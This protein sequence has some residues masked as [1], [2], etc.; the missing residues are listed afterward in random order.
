MQIPDG[1]QR[2]VTT[3][4]PATLFMLSL[5]HPEILVGVDT[6]SRRDPLLLAVA[7]ELANLPGVGSKSHGINIETVLGLNPDLVI[8]YSHRDG[9]ELAGRLER[10]GCPT[11]II[12]PETF[13]TIQE[14]L[15]ILAAAIDR[16]ER[17]ELVVRAMQ[18]ALALVH[19][20]VPDKESRER[21]RVYYGAPRGF[22]STAPADML[23]DEIIR[24]AGGVNVAS[25]LKGYFKN[26][27]AEH[28][29][30]WDPETLILSR[31]IRAEADTILGRREFS[32]LPAIQTNDVY[33]FPSTLTPWD[34]PSPLSALGVLW[35][36]TRL[37]P[38]RFGDVSLMDEA[39]AFHRTLFGK[40]MRQMGGQ[41]DD[42]LP[43]EFSLSPGHKPKKQAVDPG[44]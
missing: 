13:D 27:S 22:L 5:G 20:R 9:I 24:H 21:K 19:D 18:N 3:F 33:V 16:P 38:E 15:Y 31:T 8:L 4:K 36:G 17:G 28:L 41:L 32:F 29:I 12:Q 39:D 2:V 44:P 43:G 7:P 10:S 6:P 35:L 34:F 11:V 26:I 25:H 30:E 14:T 40:S 23:Q 42:K 37:Y 1:V